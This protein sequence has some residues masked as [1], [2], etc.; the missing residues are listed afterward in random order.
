MT[1]IAEYPD[2]TRIEFEHNTDVYAAWRDDTS[3]RHAG[4]PTG[5]GGRTW[6]LYPGCVPITFATLCEDFGED[7]IALAVRLTPHPDDVHKRRLWPTQ[8]WARK[9]TPAE[10]SG[11]HPR[12]SRRAGVGQ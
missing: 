8:V 1:G 2:G 4:Y 12:K 5:D 11:R 7:V 10:R 6:V 3:S 9:G